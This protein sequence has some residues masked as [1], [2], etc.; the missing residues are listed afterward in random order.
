M[1]TIR[2]EDK[3]V[4]RKWTTNPNAVDRNGCFVFSPL[5]A[6]LINDVSLYIVLTLLILPT[7]H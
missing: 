2:Q 7:R 1:N 4:D 6:N 5:F 3:R